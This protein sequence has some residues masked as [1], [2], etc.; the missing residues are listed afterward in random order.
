MRK[1]LVNLM[2]IMVMMFGFFVF[3][4]CDSV[5]LL[6]YKATKVIELEDYAEAKGVENYTIQ[7]WLILEQAITDGKFAI[8]NATTKLKVVEAFENAKKVIDRV[9]KN[10]NIAE[11]NAIMF[12]RAI[13]WMHSDYIEKNA[14]RNSM[15]PE[16]V[17]YPK[18]INHFITSQ[19]DFEIAFSKFP[20][21]IN[22]DNEML[23]IYFF[24]GDILINKLTGDRIFTYRI[25]DLSILD[26]CLNIV[27]A[28]KALVSGPTGSPPTQEC[29]V[30]KMN[31]ANVV[32]AIIELI[33]E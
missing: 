17:T 6:D 8:E 7:N 27:F 21:S 1:K 2:I 25:N 19:N 13:E 9:E 22:F 14:T 20:T 18:T 3:T 31:K 30:V 29:L 24:T 26:D 32:E 15:M 10:D 12:D 4:G 11:Y 33:Y 28:K 16:S 23:V 5:N